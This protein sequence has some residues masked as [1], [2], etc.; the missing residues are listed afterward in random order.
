MEKRYISQPKKKKE[1]SYVGLLAS[2][3][4]V[5][6]TPNCSRLISETDPQKEKEKENKYKRERERD[7]SWGPI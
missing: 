2:Q 6:I 1:K 7:W 4:K 3:L 5:N